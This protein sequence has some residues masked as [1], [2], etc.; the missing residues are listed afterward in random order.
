MFEVNLRHSSRD[1]PESLVIEIP[2]V[3]VFSVERPLDCRRS[4]SQVAH[5]P[6][7]QIFSFLSWPPSCGVF[8]PF[9]PSRSHHHRSSAFVC[10]PFFSGCDRNGLFAVLPM[11]ETSFLFTGCLGSTS[12]SSLFRCRQTGRSAFGAVRSLYADRGDACMVSFKVEWRSESQL[13]R[14]RWNTGSLEQKMMVGRGQVLGPT[15]AG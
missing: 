13:H 2:S 1:L 11:R 9:A 3:R 12:F 7:K 14:R 8:A 4:T 10:F 15:V 6:M 5:L